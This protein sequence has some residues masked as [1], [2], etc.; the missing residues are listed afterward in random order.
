MRLYENIKNRITERFLRSASDA[1]ILVEAAARRAT[2]LE[3][4]IIPHSTSMRSEDLGTWKSA[5]QAALNTENPNRIL[6]Y[7][8]YENV[9][10]DNHLSSIIESRILRVT[11]SPF[12]VIDSEGGENTDLTALLEGSWFEHFLKHTIGARFW[13]A[14]LIELVMDENGMSKSV[15]IPRRNTDVHKK[16]VYL[17]PDDEKGISY[18]K[19]P[20]SGTVVEVGSEQDLG[21]LYKAAPIALAKKYAIGS[22]SE[23][24]EKFGIP[25]RWVTTDITNDSRAKKLGEIMAAMGG[26]GWG[27]F[28]KGEEINV[29]DT[30]GTSAHQIFDQL[31]ERTNKEMSKL[32]LGQTMTTDDG[33]SHSQAEVHRRVAE[34]RHLSDKMYVK[35]VVNA[36][37]LPRLTAMGIGSFEGYAFD[38][39]TTEELTLTELI[40][41]V[42]KL[43][44]HY[45]IDTDYITEK[46][47]IPILGLKSS[48]S[49]TDQEDTDREGEPSKKKEADPLRKKKEFTKAL[50]QI[51]HH[52][53]HFHGAVDPSAIDLS[54][55]VELMEAIA[56]DTYNGKLKP[57]ELSKKH[58]LKTYNELYNAAK[59]GFGKDFVKVNK[60][61]GTPDITAIKMQRNIFRFSQAKDFSMLTQLNKQLVKNGKA[62]TWQEFR[63]EAL[64]LNGTYNQSYLQAEFQTARQAGHHAVNWA[65]YQKNKDRYPN[66]KYTTQGDDRVRDKHAQLNGIIKSVD[67]PF[68]DIYYP[69]NG[70]R[71]RC[72][73]EQ[74]TQGANN[75]E[76]KEGTIA[77]QFK[78]N[79]GKSGQVYAENPPK[80][81]KPHPYFNLAKSEGRKLQRVMELQKL[82]APLNTLYTAKNGATVKASPFADIADLK[83]N[84]KTARNIANQLREDVTIKA[85]LQAEVKNPEFSIKGINGDKAVPTTQ[86]LQRGVSNAFDDKFKKGRQLR[87]E[88]EAFIVLDLSSYPNLASQ[89]NV[90]SRQSWSKFTH[91]ENVK[92][93]YL[94]WNSKVVKITKTE[95]MNFKDFEKKVLEI[96]KGS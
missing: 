55:W 48:G 56:R 8:V 46:T 90:L 43:S 17:N 59:K 32:I 45:E 73:V 23:Y 75:R 27:V 80:G 13:G 15:L 69:P 85:H 4:K 25:F 39:D 20:Q 28:K 78:G 71:C 41:T 62:T 44:N 31:I 18:A 82:D 96:A 24:T 21:L 64:K 61:T 91:Y 33:S 37:L 94:E 38:W 58:V 92:C 50:L 11:G 49:A 42:T 83:S 51:E 1:D 60:A 88:R 81:G 95:G 16:V 53:S 77:D 6:L 84:I 5:V 10:I 36:E 57:G 34:D 93:L 29:M 63:K 87:N 3:S 2:S 68:W 67:D 7:G 66:L 79:V 72:Y 40:D 47:G 26:A 12:R 52:Y 30:S 14:T 22:W 89:L 74:T 86:N 35:N 19:P 9:L 54:G 76:V 65:E 70:W